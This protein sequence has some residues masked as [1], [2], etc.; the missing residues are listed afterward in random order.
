MRM[1]ADPMRDDVFGMGNDHRHQ[2]LMG[3]VEGN[4]HNSSSSSSSDDDGNMRGPSSK[5]CDDPEK[6]RL[7]G[8]QKPVHTALGGGKRMLSF[9]PSFFF[10]CFL[11]KHYY[12][13]S[14]IL[15]WIHGQIKF[16]FKIFYF[17]FF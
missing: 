13:L 8:R 12:T 14:S 17:E 10:S 7:F 2:T 5:H 15:V 16:D 4:R 3:K 11:A 9:F 6:F 1:A